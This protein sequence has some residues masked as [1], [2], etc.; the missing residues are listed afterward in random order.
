MFVSRRT[1]DSVR[2]TASDEQFKLRTELAAAQS[3]VAAQKSTVEFLMLRV[4]QLEAERNKL[5]WTYTGIKFPELVAAAEPNG[6]SEFDNPIN[7]LPS[8]EDMGD[9]QALKDGYGWD[10]EGNLTLHGRRIS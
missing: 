2:Q 5:L 7:K 8:L 9:D 6:A 3:L 10:S 1:F 4:T